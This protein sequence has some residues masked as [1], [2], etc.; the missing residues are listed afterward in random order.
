VRILGWGFDGRQVYVD[1]RYDSLGRLSETD[2]PRFAAKK[3]GET[4]DPIS[5][6]ASR[7]EYDALGR[8]VRQITKAEGGA[9]AISTTQYQGLTTRLKNPLLQER[10]ELRNVAGQLEKVTDANA[11]NTL[12]EYEQF[13]NLGKT[14]DPNGN[15]IIVQYDRLGRKTQLNDP[16]L[17]IINYS[18]DPLGQTWAQ[19][20]PKQAV[21]GKKTYF[22]FDILGRMTARHESDNAGKFESHWLYDTAA[23]GVGQLAEA[24]TGTPASKDYRR[25]HTY[26]GK[27]RPDVTTQLIQNSQFT[28]KARYDD[29]GRPISSDYQRDADGIKSYGMRY[30]AFGY[31]ERIERGPL[32]LWR[33]TE[34]D[35]AA[36]VTA[37][38]LGNG[39]TQTRTYDAFSRRMSG[40]LLATGAGGKRLEEGYAYDLIGSVKT[41]TQGWDTGSFVEMFEYD[42]L[43]RL[44]KSTVTGKPE[45]IF[46]YDDAGNMTSKTGLGVYSLRPQGP[47]KPL[48]HAVLSI[49]GIA[50]TFTYDANG[51]LTSGAGRVICWNSFDMPTKI[52]AGG[53]VSDCSGGTTSSSFAY[54]PEHQRTR[55]VRSDGTTIVYAGAQEVELN[56]SGTTVKTYWPNGLGVE[57]DRPNVSASELSWTHADRLGSIVGLSDESGA[58]RDKLEYDAWGK[59]RSTMDHASLDNNIEGLKDNKGFTGHEML[60]KLD[61]VHMNGRVYDPLIG[62]FM[63]ADPV[64]D[65]LMN[66]QRYNRY[67]YV[68]NNPTNEVDPTGFTD[69]P[70]PS[71]ETGGIGAKNGWVQCVAGHCGDDN[72]STNSEPG[73]TGSGK[74]DPKAG[75]DKGKA[76]NRESAN[77]TEP[78][79]RKLGDPWHGTV[80]EFRVYDEQTYGTHARRIKMPNFADQEVG[81]M[82]MIAASGIPFER[83]LVWGYRGFQAYKAARA[84]R[85]LGKFNVAAKNGVGQVFS[86]A[87]SMQGKTI[88]FADFSIGT[89]RGFIG[90]GEKGAAELL[91]PMKEL[92]EYSRA[93]GAELITLSGKYATEEGAALGGGR[94]GEAFSYTFEA[95]RDGLK[96]FLKRLGN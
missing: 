52:A 83:P 9:D 58:L 76:S 72:E 77:T 67:S 30:N 45:Q 59:R 14:T 7:T 78:T 26:D 37:A 73:N 31:V 85:S 56:A 87:V 21:A 81:T 29:W 13:G 75:S 50:G 43:N 96:E 46:T 8:V 3:A 88:T 47:G 36:R 90:F 32:V 11:K 65:D 64:I 19:Q 55:Q 35:A 6:L 27:G 18:I 41:R 92:V 60:E 40:A 71:P 94:V 66:G 39:L 2:Q 68:L 48:P 61:L 42:G 34:Q 33:A 57:I 62:K 38:T 12:F 25:L 53:I 79:P 20:S 84:V 51:N 70:P 28:S 91:G 22:I 24:F 17:G 5:Y 44:T 23:M 54:G 63:S 69:E 16:D 15:E 10:V 93:Q 86:P 74:K 95:S 49:A 82:L 1:Q 4:Q 80:Q 89:S